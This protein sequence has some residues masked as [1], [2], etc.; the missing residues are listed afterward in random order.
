MQKFHEPPITIE[1]SGGL[2][3]QLFQLSAAMVISEKTNR[4]F[5][6]DP[7][8]LK[9]SVLPGVQRRSL[10]IGNLLRPNEMHSARTALCQRIVTPKS[11]CL[12]EEGPLDDVIARIGNSTERVFGYFQRY[13][14]AEQVHP[15]IIA[16]LRHAAIA[17]VNVQNGAEERIAIHMRRG[18]YLK[19]KTR[20]FHGLIDRDYFVSAV[21]HIS[22]VTGI[23]SVV[24]VSDNLEEAYAVLFGLL[25]SEGFSVIPHNQQSEWND[26]GIL[27]NSAA[28]VMS[29]SSF[30]WWGAY[31]AYK[32]HNAVVVAPSPWFTSSNG[33]ES[34]LFARDWHQ[35]QS[36]LGRESRQK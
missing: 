33:V 24:I 20:K 17:G 28:V 12:R 21:R 3:N 25:S 34:I 9:L 19:M 36:G 32:Q 18:D 7:L 6:L 8:N 15:E 23:R 2:G 30:S 11:R 10:S 35:I 29:N 13:G 31:L 22:S 4:Q 26:L 1:L 27:A 14:V 5:K 16:R